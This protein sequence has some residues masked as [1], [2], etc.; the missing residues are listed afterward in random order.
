MFR[1]GS[2]LFIPAYLTVTLYRAFAGGGEGNSFLVMTGKRACAVRSRCSPWSI[3][4]VISTAIRYCGTTFSYTSVAIL[5][6]Y[7]A[8]L[9]I[10]GMANGLAQSIVSLARFF[11]PVGPSPL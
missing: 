10:I 4:L 7:M 8:P 6:N 3:A 1:I 11:G 9:H 2:A 5:L